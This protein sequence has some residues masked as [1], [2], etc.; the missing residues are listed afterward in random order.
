MC[1]FFHKWTRWVTKH[2]VV[3]DRSDRSTVQDRE[4]LRCGKLVWRYV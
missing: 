3:T 4:C 1:F 2:G